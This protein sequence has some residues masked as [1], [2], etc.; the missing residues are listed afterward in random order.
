M[1]I[2]KQQLQ[3][4]IKPAW[5]LSDQLVRQKLRQLQKELQDIGDHDPETR[6]HEIEFWMLKKG[7]YP[8]NRYQITRRF[9]EFNQQWSKRVECSST[10]E[11]M[12]AAEGMYKALKDLLERERYAKKMEHGE[13][14]GGQECMGKPGS[15]NRCEICF[16]LS[17]KETCEKKGWSMGFGRGGLAQ[18]MVM[19]KTDKPMSSGFIIDQNNVEEVISET[20][21]KLNKPDEVESGVDEDGMCK[22]CG[23]FG[24][25]CKCIN[26]D[27]LPF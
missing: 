24:E 13:Q 21:E 2:K 12:Q 18:N 17:W 25:D 4:P 27:D 1:S 23:E 20:L 5:D 14:L 8:K 16:P 19:P 3:A 15:E 9:Y 10:N 11:N 26:P 22:K 6:G 7:Y